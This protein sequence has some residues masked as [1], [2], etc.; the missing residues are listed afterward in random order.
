MNAENIVSH[1]LSG[2]PGPAS[3]IHQ[4]SVPAWS[5]EERTSIRLPGGETRTARSMSVRTAC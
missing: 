1:S 4:C 2:R 5:R 3:W